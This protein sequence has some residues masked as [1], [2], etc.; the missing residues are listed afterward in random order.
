MKV[1]KA[2]E[3]KGKDAGSFSDWVREA[4]DRFEDNV[5]RYKNR[6]TPQDGFGICG[7]CSQFAFAETEFQVLFCRCTQFE[8]NLTSR[9]PVMNCTA[10]SEKGQLKLWQMQE[11]ALLIDDIDHPT[12]GF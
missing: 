8:H 10:F 7:K 9:H 12:I 5:G 3:L 6:R 1:T 11:I 2:S 4:Q